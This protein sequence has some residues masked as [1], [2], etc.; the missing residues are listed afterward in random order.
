MTGQTSKQD[1]QEVEG[2]KEDKEKHEGS[3]KA[4]KQ[5]KAWKYVLLTAFF[6]LCF[7]YF[8]SEIH[9]RICKE[10]SIESLSLA[11]EDTEGIGWS[12]A[13]SYAKS[14]GASKDFASHYSLEEIQVI[15]NI[16]F[17]CK[18][19]AD[20]KEIM[21]LITKHKNKEKL[22]F[23]EKELLEEFMDRVNILYAMMK[24]KNRIK[25]FCELKKYQ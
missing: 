22:E 11:A 4:K 19:K 15:R 10:E 16:S 3:A 1:E 6:S 2:D 23:E 5:H 13:S 17:F 7:V 21:K 9:R 8:F 25:M 24:E 18:V 12:L 14:L 20:C